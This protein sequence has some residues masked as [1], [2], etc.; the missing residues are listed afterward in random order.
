MQYLNRHIGLY[1]LFLMLPCTLPAQDSDS[2]TYISLDPYYFH[3]EYLIDST[4]IMI[5]VREFFEYRNARIKDAVHI[6]TSKGFEV[7]TDTIGKDRSVFLY[8]Y[9]D[10]RSRD[11][12]EFFISKGYTKVYN[13]E[14]GIIQWRRD[15]MPVDRSRV[16][17]R[18]SE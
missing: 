17:R 1:T 10:F 3:L 7:A 5:D 9:N 14:G 12:A 8:C 6:P 16:R 11:A 2:V 18:R 15:N 13:L 4:S